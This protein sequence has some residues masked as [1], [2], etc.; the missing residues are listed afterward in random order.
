M[1]FTDDLNAAAAVIS[2]HGIIL[3]PTDTIWGI[4]C[5]ATNEIAIAKIYS[6]KKREENKSMIILLNDAEYIDLYVSNP[7]KILID[8][9]TRQ[10]KPTTAIFE[11]VKN[12]PVAL[13][14]NETSVAIRI[15]KD[16]F[17]LA[18]INQCKT[19][20]VATSANISGDWFPGNFYE[21]ADEIKNGVDYVVQHRKNDLNIYSPSS[22]IKLNAEG[23]IEIIR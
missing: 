9:L 19:P 22:I 6:L 18:L 21:V 11:N 7:S 20:L 2:R 15:V 16:E 1:D 17:C 3:Y 12:L 23:E 4:G 13:I 10:D 14:R 5:D 8:F